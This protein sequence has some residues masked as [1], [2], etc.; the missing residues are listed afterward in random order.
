MERLPSKVKKV[1]KENSPLKK[2]N[3]KKSARTKKKNKKKEN[4][5]FK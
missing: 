2:K 3:K 1:V 5:F 4:S